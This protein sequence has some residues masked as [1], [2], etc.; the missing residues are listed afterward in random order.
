MVADG[1]LPPDRGEAFVKNAYNLDRE[2]PKIRESY[3]KHLGGQID[4][5]HFVQGAV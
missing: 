4:G 5:S 1:S 2:D 3:G